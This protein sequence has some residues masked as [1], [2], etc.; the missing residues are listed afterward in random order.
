MQAP[1]RHAGLAP[2]APRTCHRATADT[3]TSIDVKAKVDDPA[4]RSPGARFAA[5]IS[6]AGLAVEDLCVTY[7]PALAFKNMIFTI[8]AGE[9]VAV[10]GPNGPGKSSLA[11]AVSGP[12]APTAGHIR[13]GDTTITGWSAH[14]VRSAGVVHL[15]E[16]RRVFRSLAVTENLQLSQSK[17]GGRPAHKA[18]VEAAFEIFPALA[19]MPIDRRRRP[20]RW[21]AADA[22]AGACPLHLSP[23]D[24]RRRDVAWAR[25]EDGRRRFRGTQL[26]AP[27][28]G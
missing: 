1:V 28:W 5:P 18:A 2:G 19:E 4:T 15:P 24:R 11:W 27:A 26:D 23:V 9:V 22:V 10:L 14:A 17:T 6:A 3:N 8:G 16:G 25:T 21:R 13:L 12:A 7:G 20:V